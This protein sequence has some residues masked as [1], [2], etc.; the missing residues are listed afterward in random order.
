MQFFSSKI[1]HSPK[2]FY[3]YCVNR[4]MTLRSLKMVVVRTTDYKQMNIVT[5]WVG[6][7]CKAEAKGILVFKQGPQHP[8][9]GV[10]KTCLSTGQ[11]RC[12]KKMLE[13]R[14]G[15]GE[16]WRK[17]RRGTENGCTVTVDKSHSKRLLWYS[18]PCVFCYL[19]FPY[20]LQAFL[21]ICLSSPSNGTHDGSCRWPE[22]SFRLPLPLRLPFPYLHLS[23]AANSYS[24]FK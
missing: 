17:V 12:K 10:W 23:L 19:A 15:E 21:F 7:S 5:P 4:D 13:K 9:H 16:M 8:H 6:S 22:L 11:R 2:C 1:Q 20:V 3:F 14:G 18:W 24:L